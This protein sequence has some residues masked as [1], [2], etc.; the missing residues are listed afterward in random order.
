MRQWRCVVYPI[1]NFRAL[2]VNNVGSYSKE[3]NFRPDV[4][5][6][7]HDLP[8]ATSFPTPEFFLQ[9]RAIGHRGKPVVVAKWREE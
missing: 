9:V 3:S 5:S 6:L 7:A 2:T 1:R 4:P 8:L